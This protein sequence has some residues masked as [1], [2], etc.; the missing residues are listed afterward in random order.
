M[1]VNLSQPL[2][3]QFISQ[4]H[5]ILS[6]LHKKLLQ[7]VNKNMLTTIN[8]ANVEKTQYI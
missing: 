7:F 1:Q 6:Q 4:V 5:F 8:R 3:V 2:K